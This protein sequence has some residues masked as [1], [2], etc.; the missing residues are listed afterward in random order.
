MREH[1]SEGLL[2]KKKQKQLPKEVASYF[3]SFDR[4]NNNCYPPLKMAIFLSWMNRR[5]TINP[6]SK[7]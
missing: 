5:V 3:F 4:D 7:R 1:Y 6:F 2:P